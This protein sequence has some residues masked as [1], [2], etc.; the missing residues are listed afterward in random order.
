[1]P[2][3][4]Q[5]DLDRGVDTEL[6]RRI[7]EQAAARAAAPLFDLAQFVHDALDGAIAD[8][9]LPARYTFATF[10]EPKH[11]GLTAA[12]RP[13]FVQLETAIVAR[14]GRPLFTV[15]RLRLGIAFVSEWNRR[16]QFTSSAFYTSDGRYF[17][18]ESNRRAHQKLLDE[19]AAR[20]AERVR[21]RLEP[22]S[23]R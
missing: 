15:E 1:M 21:A 16:A 3:S 20:H 19:R 17:A 5:R 7:R 6:T 2:R 14:V 12:Q 8:L 9:D 4:W 22:G 13:V 11:D 18:E 10:D 23:I